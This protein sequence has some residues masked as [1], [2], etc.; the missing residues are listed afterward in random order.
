MS[1]LERL[2]S[3]LSLNSDNLTLRQILRDYL[4]LE[5]GY[6]EL[7]ALQ[8]YFWDNLCFPAYIPS[9]E[10]GWIANKDFRPA[11]L[12]CVIPDSGF[13]CCCEA[14]F[15]RYVSNAPSIDC[16]TSLLEM[17]FLMSKALD[18][19][20]SKKVCR[21]S[22]HAIFHTDTLYT[23]CYDVAIRVYSV[24]M[25]T[26]ELRCIVNRDGAR[27]VNKYFRGVLNS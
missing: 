18:A 19:I 25:H 17:E 1:D 20:K 4:E 2:Y 7:L 6:P 15:N 11:N 26:C 5:G 16:R 10:V 22:P 23:N 8:E 9:T 24:T 12:S 13:Y 14:L 3:E 27:A 21:L